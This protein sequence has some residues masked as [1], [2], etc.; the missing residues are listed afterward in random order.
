MKITKLFPTAIGEEFNINHNLI[1]NDITEHCTYLKNNTEKGGNNW[2]VD[3][4][5]SIGTYDI[6]QDNKFKPLNDWI[7]K[8]VL[9]YSYAL[10]LRNEKINNAYGWFNFYEQHDYQE[11]HT[12]DLYDISAVYYVK[13]P[14]NSGNIKFYSPEPG[15]VK[16]VFDKDNLF[17][18]KDFFYEPKEGQLLMFKSNLKHGVSQNKSNESKISL[19]YNFKF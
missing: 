5:N 13:T 10:G 1:K 7:C 3:T 8:Q 2:D 15:G 14:K 19:A 18:Y 17:T 4:F 9:H 11:I 12:H 6:L 16:N